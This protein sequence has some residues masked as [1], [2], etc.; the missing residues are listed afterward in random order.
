[1]GAS[2]STKRQTSVMRRGC[3]LSEFHVLHVSDLDAVLVRIADAVQL[4]TTTS[5]V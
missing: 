4:Y 5:A 3:G 2:A 1:M